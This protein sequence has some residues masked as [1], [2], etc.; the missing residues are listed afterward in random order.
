MIQFKNMKLKYRKGNTT[1]TEFMDQHTA[2]VY[3]VKSKNI[4][5]IAH[6][7]TDF[8]GRKVGLSDLNL[9]HVVKGTFKIYRPVQGEKE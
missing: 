9:D 8:S 6:Q 3:E 7:N 2:V 1:F 4:F 5:T